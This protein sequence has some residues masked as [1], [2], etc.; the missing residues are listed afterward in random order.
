MQISQTNAKAINWTYM[1]EPKIVT[2]SIDLDD[3]RH[4]CVVTDCETGTYE[5]ALIENSKVIMNS[6]NGYGSAERALMHGL[7]ECA[8]EDY[9]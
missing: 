6:D 4:L 8:K 3:N 1:N 9:L 7:N 2:H 5:W